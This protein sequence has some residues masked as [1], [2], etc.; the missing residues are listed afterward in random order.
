MKVDGLPFQRESYKAAHKSDSMTHSE[1]M[2]DL[3]YIEICA[4]CG[5]VDKVH[6]QT[7]EQNKYWNEFHQAHLP[8][9]ASTLCLKCMGHFMKFKTAIDD[10]KDLL[11]CA[12][13]IERAISCR[14]QFLK[15]AEKSKQL[16]SLDRC[17]S[18]RLKEF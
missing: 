5:A 11:T 8:I 12:N 10:C 7:E 17:L 6:D 13:Y 15:T 4:R 1:F 14:K 18:T 2:A 3:D 16:V 9:P